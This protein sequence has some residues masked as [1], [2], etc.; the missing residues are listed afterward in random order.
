[1][2][3]SPPTTTSRS[4]NRDTGVDPAWLD[5]AQQDAEFGVGHDII[6]GE[7]LRP[8]SDR[9]PRPGAGSRDGRRP[10]SRRRRTG[11][12]R[13][14]R[15]RR[16]ASRS[17]AAAR[18]GRA[19][20]LVPDELPLP[21]PVAD[22][23]L[24]AVPEG[25]L[26]EFRGQGRSI[27]YRP[28]PSKLSR[29]TMCRVAIRSPAA[30]MRWPSPPNPTRRAPSGTWASIAAMSCHW[31]SV[32]VIPRRPAVPAVVQQVQHLVGDGRRVRRAG[33]PD[34]AAS[35]PRSPP[36]WPARTAGTART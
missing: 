27:R 35:P 17:H 14:A 9:P 11:G 1:M 16:A 12:V 23:R 33:V 34:P 22:D 32:A 13:A 24:P 10:R 30:S 6:G 21:L 7:H 4:S 20:H 25:A 15:R 31:C 8:R 36:A 19:S 29:E 18:P 5:H 3:I 26:G 2:R 28:D